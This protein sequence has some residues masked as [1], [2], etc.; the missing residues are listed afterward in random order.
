LITLE[1]RLDRLA[2]EIDRHAQVFPWDYEFLL[3][4]DRRQPSAGL[5][6]WHAYA[7]FPAGIAHIG[8][9]A[10]EGQFL[11]SAHRTEGVVLRESRKP[12]MR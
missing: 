8:A 11:F 1:L 6:W 5:G 4:Q 7:F 9:F 12:V 3:G 2:L 10:D